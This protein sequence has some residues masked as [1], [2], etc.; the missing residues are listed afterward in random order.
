MTP[1]PDSIA[2]GQEAKLMTIWRTLMICAATTATSSIG[3][4]AGPCYDQIYRMEARLESLLQAKSAAGPTAPQSTEA[5]LHRQP[6]RE[7][8]A[9]V[10][11]RLGLASPQAAEAVMRGMASARAADR[12]GDL[13]A[14]ER[15]LA[16]VESA[17]AQAPTQ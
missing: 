16:D 10:V 6:T 17:I 7:S 2:R 15:A 14:C 1:A 13:N 11:T 3:A 4:Q 12:A 8:I 5:L 9:A